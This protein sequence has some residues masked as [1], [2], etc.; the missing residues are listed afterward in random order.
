MNVAPRPHVGGAH[1][2]RRLAGAAWALA[3]LTV[4]AC[5]SPPSSS[6]GALDA[7]TADAGT[8][9]ADGSAG[10]DAT[11]AGSALVADDVHPLALVVAARAG[12]LAQAQATWPTDGEAVW[13]GFALHGAPTALVVLDAKGMPRRGYLVGVSAQPKGGVAVALPATGLPESLSGPLAAVPI[14]RY[15]AVTADMGPGE[16][17]IPS[18]AVAEA[19]AVVATWSPYRDTDDTRWVETL[20]RGYMVRLRESEASWTGVQ[21]CGQ[22]VYPRFAEAIA[23]VQLECAVLAE[24]VQAAD[25]ATAKARLHEWAAARVA[26]IAVTNFVG[27]RVRHY[28]NIFGSERFVAGRL[29]VAAGLRDT[30]AWRAALGAWLAKPTTAPVADFDALLLDSGEI[31]A[32]AIEAAGLAGWDVEPSFR[33]G[34]NVLE[35]VLQELGDPPAAA[36]AAAKARHPWADYQARAKSVLALDGGATP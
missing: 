23:L 34:G 29:T 10:A 9:G 14:W 35:V 12:S 5:A 31:A 22:T 36:L 26:G 13:P 1:A 20:A 24:A 11:S 3:A 21:A 8:A 25:A 27:Q 4:A 28:D 17:V 15:D 33:K 19:D 30:K 16:T 7:G 32:A 2:R 6:S 18:R